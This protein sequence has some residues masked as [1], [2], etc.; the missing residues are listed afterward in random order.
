MFMAEMLSSVWGGMGKATQSV[1]WDQV[2]AERLEQA[3]NFNGG[4]KE[5]QAQQK[6]QQADEVRSIAFPQ[7]WQLLKN[8]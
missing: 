3:S 6:K 8:K 5:A 1:G 4:Y 2:S 7:W